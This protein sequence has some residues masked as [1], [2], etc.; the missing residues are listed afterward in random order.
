M[1]TVEAGRRPVAKADDVQMELSEPALVGHHLDGR[2]SVTRI[3]VAECGRRGGRTTPARTVPAAVAGTRCRG[4]LRRIHSPTVP[5]H[6]LV[7]LAR[8]ED[9]QFR[10]AAC[11]RVW[12]AL[13]DDVRAALLD[14]PDPA[15]RRA[16][17]MHV[18]EHDEARTAE[19]VELLD[20]SWKLNEVAERGRLTRGVAEGLLAQGD[21]LYSL[22]L[23]PSLPADLAAGPAD[24]DDPA[25]RLA[26]SARP[27]LTEDERAA[28]DW[29]IDPEDRLDTLH[30]VWNARNDP[31]TLRACA[32][33]A[34]TWLRRSAAVCPGLPGDC[35]ELLAADPD[36]AVRLLLAERHP[37]A[38]GELLLDLYLHGTHRAV[39]MLTGR[40]NFPTTG[41]ATRFADA[42]DR[43]ARLLVLRDPDATP[44]LVERLSRDPDAWV[45]SVAGCDQRLPVRRLVE[46]PADPQAG[47][48]A[49]ANPLLPVEE[50]RALLDRAGIPDSG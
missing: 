36:F 16:A 41:L 30:W 8:H 49:A 17:A 38:P 28:V 42:P 6:V 21:R 31:D 27:G 22:A 34:H 25:V 20:D 14:D 35:V 13:D 19:L 32:T 43:D 50:M 46:L 44:E 48:S 7:P 12:H 15:V 29:K 9:G 1:L 33:S 37:E 2:L 39:L 23:N 11:E 47:W 4:G 18:M 45:R 26:F 10:L 24:H 5:V 40:P 3:M